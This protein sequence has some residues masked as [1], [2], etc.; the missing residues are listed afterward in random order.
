MATIH[1]VRRLQALIPLYVERFSCIG[2]ACEDT[3]CAGWRVS[4]DKKT[5]K[6]YKQLE[7]HKLTALLDS[8][9]KRVRSQASDSN[10]GRIELN[11]QTAECPMIEDQLC[12]I[13]KELGEDKLSNT[14][15]S[16]PRV[17]TEVGGVY[18]QSLTLS[19]PEA[20]RL[21]LL[22]DDAMEFKQSEITVRPETIEQRKPLLGLTSQQM[23]DV[24]FFCIQLVK[25]PDLLLWQKLALL[26]VFCENLTE[27]LKNGGQ[28][29]VYQIIEEMS[30][31]FSSGQF[32]NLF[33]NMKPQYEIQAVTF[34]LLWRLKNQGLTSKYQREVHDSISKSLGASSE[35]GK[36]P[37]SELTAHYE[38]GVNRI[39]EA[40]KDAPFFLENYVLNEMFR[41]NFPFGQAFPYEH[42]LR[43]I[44]RF[45]L[46]RFMLASQCAED[47]NLPSLSSLS[48]TVQTFCRR[49][50]H[51]NQFAV[52]VNN[53]LNTSGWSDLQ[54][55]F[56]FLKT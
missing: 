3:C 2:S 24:R 19:C 26:G 6:T 13:Q 35:S 23:N 25:S 16:F 47:E 18:Q 45:G 56:R 8:K 54:K 17:S 41:E 40:L 36:L 31:L 44:T 22:A 28:E 20:A 53:C 30:H 48:Q 42:Y 5:F 32:F 9:V 38:K 55:I 27:A 52:N 37:V 33:E 50:Q 7:N 34:A 39:P 15:F 21:A 43:L 14:C 4:I 49:F 11:P 51:D 46:V 1:P 29:K 10:F 12:S